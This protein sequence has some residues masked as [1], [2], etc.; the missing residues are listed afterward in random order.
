MRL[1]GWVIVSGAVGMAL[2]KTL[3]LMALGN[4]E[5]GVVSVLVSLSP[6]MQLPLIWVWTRKLPA[7]GAWAGATLAVLGTALIVG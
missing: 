1:L 4:G 6:A 3:M 2:G 5:P 7:L